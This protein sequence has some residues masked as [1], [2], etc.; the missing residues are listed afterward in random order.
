MNNLRQIGLGYAFYESD[1]EAIVPLRDSAVKD[2]WPADWPSGNQLQPR[3]RWGWIL[4]VE[5]DFSSGHGISYGPAYVPNVQTFKCP[6]NP[7]FSEAVGS[8]VPAGNE[9][10]SY[11]VNIEAAG[12]GGLTPNNDVMY[13]PGQII[14]PSELLVVMDGTY[15]GDARQ[16]SWSYYPPNF[17]HGGAT[18]VDHISTTSQSPYY[19]DGRANCLFFDGHVA[20]RDKDNIGEHFRNE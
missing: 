16:S 8:W 5:E 13:R 19:T 10:S 2:W 14:N 7:D 4:H 9:I 18:T 1:Y 12:V 6:T 11:A 15:R 3:Y 20:P 17:R